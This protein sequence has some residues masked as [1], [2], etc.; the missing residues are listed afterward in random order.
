[1]PPF[2]EIPH[3]EMFVANTAIISEQ[4]PQTSDSIQEFLQNRNYE[5][6]ILKHPETEEDL[7]IVRFSHSQ[8]LPADLPEGY[9]FI[10]GAARS[11]ILAEMGE[12]VMPPRDLDIQTLDELEP[13]MDLKDHISRTYMADDFEYG[14]GVH[15]DSMSKYFT[16]R[17]YVL[18]EAFVHGSDV[19]ATPE[20]LEDLQNKVIRPSENEQE[21]WRFYHDDSDESY[22]PTL[23]VKPKL[24]M[25]ALRLKA[26]FELM[27]GQGDVAGI[28][29]WQFDSG[30]VPAFMVA[31]HLNKAYER[32]DV[33]AY[34]YYQK[35]VEQ[36]TVKPYD[37]GDDATSG[38]I[39]NNPKDLAFELRHNMREAGRD[40]FVFDKEALNAIV[41]S[42]ASF[43]SLWDESSAFVG[44][45]YTVLP[46]LRDVDISA[47]GM[48]TVKELFNEKMNKA[49]I[50]ESVGTRED[51]DAFST[52]DSG[53]LPTA[54]ELA[55]RRSMQ[56][57]S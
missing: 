35:L 10:G 49:P 43:A 9:G 51:I 29:S 22:A 45:V 27:Y 30:E 26:E 19:Y 31:L 1:M 50:S 41:A 32:S 23:G 6:L 52:D 17:D 3:S 21:A 25:K 2:S 28:E 15:S 8:E 12:D 7:K 5:V 42:R 11:L 33:V 18:N 54:F 16:S 46:A 38:Y 48:A 24:V 20:A 14:H 36:G 44:D 40:P 56:G 53:D 39:A 57:N 13:D 47:T 34:A 55:L 37:I 4:L